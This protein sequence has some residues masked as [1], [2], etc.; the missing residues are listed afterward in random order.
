MVQRYRVSTGTASVDWYPYLFY[1]VLNEVTNDCNRPLLSEP[2]DSSDSLSLNHWVPL[3]LDQ[4]N[5]CCSCEIQAFPRIGQQRLLKPEREP[6]KV[7]PD[8]TGT[9]GHQQNRYRGVAPEL[10][11]D[12]FPV[13]HVQG[14]V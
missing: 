5:G 12:P 6:R 1:R 7:L 13:V 4:V 11:K 9:N 14:A 8:S 3:R 10:G 2:V